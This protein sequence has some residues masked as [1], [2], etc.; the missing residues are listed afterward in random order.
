MGNNIT[1]LAATRHNANSASAISV[2]MPVHNAGAYLQSAVDSIL[3]QQHVTLELII[4]DDHSSDA[5]IS[6]LRSDPRI[7]LT[8]NKQPGI[9]GA[10]NHGITL[11]RFPLIARMDGD[12]VAHPER[13]KRQ[14]DYYSANPTIDIVGAKVQI[15][16]TDE[17]LGAGFS[18]YQNWVNAQQNH[19]QISEHFF[20]ECCIPHPT[21]FMSTALARFLKGYSD[22]AWPEDYDFIAKAFIQG[23]KFGKPEQPPLLWWRDHDTRLSRTSNAY[24]RDAFLRCKAFYLAQYLSQLNV[25]EVVIWGAGPTGLKLHDYLEEQQVAVKAFYDINP[26]LEGRE[27][28][29]KPVRLF[30][31]PQDIDL[32]E[33]ISDFVLIAISARGAAAEMEALFKQ[34]GRIP[35]QD[36]LRVS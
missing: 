8:S 5:A 23:A 17:S 21:F 1:G 4:I 24:N 28:R 35:N 34:Q 12:D 20:V 22:T 36:Y 33:R 11:A 14:L 27:K 16:K 26:K 32:I 15:F 2:L 25:H 10:L 3:A 7:V 9:V 19:A 30:K 18:H 31:I 29:F 13:L 6:N